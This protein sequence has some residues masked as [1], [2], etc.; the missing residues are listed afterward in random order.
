M[1]IDPLLERLLDGGIIP[2][3]QIVVGREV[4]IVL[5]ADPQPGAAAA[6]GRGTAPAQ[7]LALAGGQRLAQ[8]EGTLRRR[9]EHGTHEDS[10]A[11]DGAVRVAS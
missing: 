5:A 6:L 7:G 3:P 9:G 8:C 2:Q 1:A 4:E 11:R 10:A